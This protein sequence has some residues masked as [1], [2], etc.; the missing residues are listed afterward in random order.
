MR[1]A[2]LGER[3]MDLRE[4]KMWTQGE[5]SERSGVSPA[6][7]NKIE[8]EH[9]ERP[10]FGTVRKLAKALGTEPESLRPDRGDEIPKDEAPE[11]ASGP[12]SYI[13]RMKVAN[14]TSALE[15]SAYAYELL[16]ADESYSLESVQ[17]SVDAAVEL[18]GTFNEFRRLSIG[19]AG[20]EGLVEAGQRLRAVRSRLR[21]A[22]K[23]KLEAE[24]ERLD[25]GKVIELRKREAEIDHRI[26]QEEREVG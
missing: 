2:T 5:L 17:A 21:Q 8:N 15:C 9:I 23:E 12:E 3:L 22:A 7:I 10:R 18:C 11:S 1:E 24:R 6:T 14:R 25:P 16:L 26:E 20:Y 19:S 13:D 4:E